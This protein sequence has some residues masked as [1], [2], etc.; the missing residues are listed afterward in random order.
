MWSS[1]ARSARD[2]DHVF[3]VWNSIRTV[4]QR[5]HTNS[6]TIVLEC[7]LGP[8]LVPLSRSNPDEPQEARNNPDEPQEPRNTAD[9]PQE[10]KQP[11]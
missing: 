4:L 5:L 8:M 10:H 1:A 7:F 2:L 11:R 3:S 6:K 9:E